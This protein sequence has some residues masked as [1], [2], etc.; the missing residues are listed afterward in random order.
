MTNTVNVAELIPRLKALREEADTTVCL[1]MS[2]FLY[3]GTLSDREPNV[4]W[5]VIANSRGVYDGATPEEAVAAAE[6]VLLTVGVAGLPDAVVL[7]A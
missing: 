4:Y 6:A 2:V 5:T 3:D 1:Q 7:P